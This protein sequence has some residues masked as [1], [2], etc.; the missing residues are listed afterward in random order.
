[1]GGAGEQLRASAPS[2]IVSSMQAMSVYP[3]ANYDCPTLILR[4]TCHSVHIKQI[5]KHLG[6]T[7]KVSQQV[8]GR[9]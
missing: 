5:H 4:L 3:H 7:L 8:G 1:M 9:Y 6:K 2:S